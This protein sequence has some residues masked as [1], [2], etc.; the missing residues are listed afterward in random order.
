MVEGRVLVVGAGAAGIAAAAMLRRRDVPVLVLERGSRPGQS[1]F[2]R[3]DGLRLNTARWV[4]DLPGVRMPRAAGTFPGRLAW[5]RYLEHYVAEQR[6]DVRVGTAVE[7]VE[8]AGE[9]WRVVTDGE[10]LLASAVVVATGHDRVPVLPPWSGAETFAGRLIHASAFRSTQKVP[11]RRVLVVGSGN[12]GCE[13]ASL[14]AAGGRDVWLSVRTPP[15][16]MPERLAGLSITSWGL[17]LTLLPDGAVDGAGRAV[18]RLLWRDLEGLGLGAS[19]DRLS[20]MR[21]R[22]YSPPIDRGIIDAVRSGAV[23]PVA[24]VDRLD[25]ARVRLADGSQLEPDLVVAA[26]G[27]RPGLEPLVGHLDVLDTDGEPCVDRD[28]CGVGTPGLYFAGF[29]YGLL[30]LLPYIEPDARRIAR[31]VAARSGQPVRRRLA[32]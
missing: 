11:E 16:L 7:R 4:S 20:E 26:T 30:A 24:A 14:L 28:R 8:Q 9:G 27:Y 17:P 10:D 6:L 18:Q 12:S 19:P 5:A 29:R 32:A 15:L 1:W 23:H 21:H 2:D 3:Y 22:Y 13:I 31:A 25:G